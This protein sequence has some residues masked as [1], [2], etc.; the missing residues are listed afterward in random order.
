MERRR[1]AADLELPPKGK[2]KGLHAPASWPGFRMGAGCRH[3]Q[4]LGC[5][6]G[7]AG[8]ACPEQCGVLSR[9]LNLNVKKLLFVTGGISSP[10]P[11]CHLERSCD[12]FN[13]KQI[14]SSL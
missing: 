12:S 1:E 7:S 4:L 13:I 11:I 6:D 2:E 10:L 5:E 9:N 8:R 14:I 3:P